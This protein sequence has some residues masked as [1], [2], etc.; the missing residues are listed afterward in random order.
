MPQTSGPI[1]GENFSDQLWR[2]LFGDEPGVVGDLDGSAYKL[3][4][5]T[6]SDTVQVG[7]TTQRSMARVAGFA[8]IIPAGETSPITIP[9]AVGSPRTDII[10]LA[11]DPTYTDGPVKLAK[12]TG[13]S[14]AI[15]SYDAAPP[16]GEFLP[17]WAL[18][19][20]PG[21]ALSQASVVDLRPRLA[22]VLTIPADTALPLSSPLG[23]TAWWR[24]ALY[25]RV[26]G[27]AGLAA[28]QRDTTGILRTRFALN[29]ASGTLAAGTQVNPAQGYQIPAAP[30]GLGVPWEA[31]V[32]ARVHLSAIPQG[33][34]ARLEIYFGD[35]V[36]GGDEFTNGGTQTC[37]ATLQ[38]RDI[39][40][41]SDNLSHG[42]A[43]K[44][45]A[46]GGTIT[47]STLYGRFIVEGRV[48]DGF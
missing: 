25:R 46:L 5:P 8:H 44:L 47:V 27:T 15:P 48:M 39:A 9:V 3:T 17:L 11:Y 34:G 37:R 14:T 31:T 36:I 21:Q 10:G 24:G 38:A 22:P 12:I 29:T 43:A 18:T 6:N 1:V 45:T 35:T 19:R 16:G 33:C 23:T 20:T 26:L 28:W 7:S 41:V 2:D 30:F 32:D 40:Y 13:T 4:L 42:V